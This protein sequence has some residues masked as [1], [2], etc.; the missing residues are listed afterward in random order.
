MRLW[1]AVQPEFLACCSSVVA[2][3]I[4]ASHRAR[5]HGYGWPR[6][7][8]PRMTEAAVLGQAL[9]THATSSETPI[10]DMWVRMAGVW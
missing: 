4:S 7:S 8:K 10:L 5:T 1:V 3:E 9:P 2:P 6:E